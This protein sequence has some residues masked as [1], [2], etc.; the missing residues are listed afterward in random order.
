MDIE[1]NLQKVHDGVKAV[2]DRVDKVNGKIDAI[3]KD[4]IEKASKDAGD[5]LEAINKIKSEAKLEEVL[6]KQAA[7]ESTIIGMQRG[8]GESESNPEYKNGMDRYLR[9]GHAVNEDVVLEE[10]KNYVAKNT[11]G[12]DDVEVEMLAKDLLAGSGPDGGYF[13]TTD[14]SNAIVERIFE[15]S[16]LRGLA[17]IETTN[18]DVFEKIIDD[19]EA[20]CGWV[21]EVEER[22][23]TN[24]PPVGVL[25]IPIHEVY[26]QPKATQKILDDAGFNIENW[27]SNKVSRRIGRKENTAFVLGDGSQKPKGFLS[28][29]AWAAAGVYERNKVEQVNSGTAGGFDGDA[30]IK[31]Q[32]SLLEDYQANATFGMKRALF[33][34]VMQLKDGSGRY[35]LNPAILAEGSDKMLLGNDVAFMADMPAKAGDALAIIYADFEEFYTIVDRFGIR[36]IRDNL[37]EKPYTK[38][39][40]TKRVGGAVENFQAGK[41]LKLAV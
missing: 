6:E 15:T 36:V 17:N 7:M 41:I 4:M 38:F 8:S 40:T 20:D 19:N 11:F 12:T 30:I 34:D 37:T 33:T 9:K 39:Y 25:R 32:N 28:Y 5:A 24:T 27:L 14:R 10:V 26:A 3:D 2:Q 1:E 21:G 22:A 18:S 29:D 16:P 13:V 23:D 31:L 35:L